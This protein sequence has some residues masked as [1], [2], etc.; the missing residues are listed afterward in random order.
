MA[1]VSYAQN[2][3]DVMLFR[4]LKHLQQG[5]YIDIGANHPTEDSVTKAFYSRGWTGVNVEPVSYWFEQLKQDRPKD[6]NL[7]LAISDSTHPLAF[8]EV[9]ES[10]LSTL[11]AARAEACRAE[12]LTVLQ[13]TVDVWTLARLFE[14][15]AQPQTHF[16]KI[17]VEGAET[18][19]IRSGDWE[20]HRPWIVLVESTQPNT[21]ISEHDAWE[22]ILLNHGYRFVW[23]DGI[24]R[25]YLA[26]EH[27]H[28]ASAFQHPINVLDHYVTYREVA[29]IESRCQLILDMEWKQNDFQTELLSAKHAISTANEAHGN[30]LNILQTQQQQLQSQQQMLDAQNALLGWYHTDLLIKTAIRVRKT[31]GFCKRKVIRVLR[32]ALDRVIGGLDKSP[33]MKSTLIEYLRRHPALV[34]FLQRLTAR[35]LPLLV[36]AASVSADDPNRQAESVQS[37]LKKMNQE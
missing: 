4:A 33:K 31:P 36:S 1:F 3:E 21:N 35:P 34:R 26:E 30:A 17:D 27:S 37:L 13:N 24:N 7:Q 11:D 23:F 14:H 25:F 20:R 18:Q 29:L 12:G 16:L 22:P 28:L 5:C 9:A 2:A 10:G 32:N 8:Y 6:N 15:A 19:V